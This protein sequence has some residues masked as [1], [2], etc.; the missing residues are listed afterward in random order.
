MVNIA[1]VTT[2][3]HFGACVHMIEE[4][5]VALY[6]A[7]L[8]AQLKIEYCITD[9]VHS[10]LIKCASYILPR[11]LLATFSSLKKSEL[12]STPRRSDTVI[13]CRMHVQACSQQAHTDNVCARLRWP[14]VGGAKLRRLRPLLPGVRPSGRQR[15]PS[16]VASHDTTSGAL[17][18]CGPILSL[19]YEVQAVSEW[20]KYF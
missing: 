13:T 2:H 19:G 11:A 18:C 15:S 16:S 7:H 10:R 5:D 17:V 12:T 4:C 9:S 3:F 14:H 20:C 1:A 8:E 6:S